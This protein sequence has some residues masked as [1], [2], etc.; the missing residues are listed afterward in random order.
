MG[1]GALSLR[2]TRRSL[3]ALSAAAVAAPLAVACGGT[4]GGGSQPAGAPT[5]PATLSV[6]FNANPLALGVQAYAQTVSEFQEKN[7][8]IKVTAEP[9]PGANTTEQEEKILT[10]AAAGSLPDLSYVHPVSNATFAIRSVTVPLEPYLSKKGSSFDLKDFYPGAIDYFR[11]DSKLWA[12]PNYSGPNIF[13]YNKNLL[14]QAGLP[15]PWEQYQKGEWTIQRYDDAVQRLTR[16]QGESKVFGTREIS[17]SIRNQSPWIQGFGGEVWNAKATETLLNGDGAVRAWEY[18]SG[19]VSKGLAPSPD[20]LRG[21]S[22]GNT[23][24]FVA[25]RLGFYDGIRSE[26]T[27]FKDVQFGV[28]PKHKMADGKE[29]NRDGPNGM[30]LT[31]GTKSPDAAWTFLTFNVTRGVEVGLSLGLTA[32]TTRTLAKNP[33]WL[34]QL[35]PGEQAK[36]YDA[37]AT[38]VKA[39]LLPPRLSEMDKL[40]QDAYAR[41]IAGQ[42]GAK[43]AMTEIKPQVDAILASN[44]R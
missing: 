38:Q 35:V 44:G 19:Q 36:A 1:T 8:T 25:G 23:G 16:G 29:Y 27:G 10:A 40:I 9:L 15:D 18:L 39:I 7:P 37:A 13:Y 42:A 5:A 43:Q 32:P 31:K 20:D 17:R 21:V 33:A 3:Y 28:V 34:N 2:R 11:W 6:W 24:V 41:V 4:S 30:T 26:V 12:L 22:G 14:Q